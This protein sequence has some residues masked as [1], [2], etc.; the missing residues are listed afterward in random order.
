MKKLLALLLTL[1]MTLS[2]AACSNSTG[3]GGSDDSQNSAAPASSGPSDSGGASGA[4]IP[5]SELK[6]ALILNGSITDASWNA[7]GYNALKANADEMGFEWTYIENVQ[8]ADMEASIRD[9]CEQGYN[10]IMAHGS[11]FGD[12]MSAVAPSY[13]DTYFFVY[14]G[15][16][17]TGGN[18]ST[19]RNSADENAFISGVIAALASE[20][21]TIGWV[22][23]M[24]VP[25]TTEV[26]YGY[27]AGAKYIDPEINILSAY[28]GSYNDTAKAKE[29]TLTMFEQGAD[30]IQSNANQGTAG[31]IEAAYEWGTDSGVMLISDTNDRYEDCPEFQLTASIISFEAAYKIPITQVIEGTWDGST[32]LG[33]VANGVMGNAPYHDLEDRLT[34][35]EKATVEQVRT[36]LVDGKLFAYLPCDY[37]RYGR[38]NE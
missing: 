12:A 19:I 34:D 25:T 36:D 15:E 24:E 16:L 35:E 8:A 20:T 23:A 14:N 26:F 7:N 2:L 11:Q 38:P 33:T 17:E 28:V 5:V 18:L 13:P 30:V 22:G 21:G 1:A 32:V 9:F 27:E 37:S 10:L 4:G 3:S 31:V 29:I 6:V